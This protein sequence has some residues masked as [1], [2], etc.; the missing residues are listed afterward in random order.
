MVYR[1]EQTFAIP[2]AKV[3]SGDSFVPIPSTRRSRS[4]SQ[5]VLKDENRP[6]NIIEE[7]KL[8]LEVPG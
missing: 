2:L 3:E 5:S 6:I 8:S 4:R 1:Q 7:D